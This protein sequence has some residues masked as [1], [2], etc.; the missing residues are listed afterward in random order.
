MGTTI[1]FD[2]MVRIIGNLDHS[3]YWTFTVSSFMEL[4]ADLATIWGSE[5]FGRRWSIAGGLLISSVFM[6]VAGLTIS[7]YI[8]GLAQN[9]K[10]NLDMKIEE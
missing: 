2:L 10:C 6:V 7:K 8:L 4:P 9:K 1:L 5:F 3:I